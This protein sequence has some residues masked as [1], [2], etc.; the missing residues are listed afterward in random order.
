MGFIEY[1]WDISLQ[2][3]NVKTRIFM[4]PK[5]Q[6][7]TLTRNEA[8]FNITLPV[9]SMSE[10]GTICF[11]GCELPADSF[12]KAK[13]GRLF[14][15][16]VF[17][18]TAHTLMPICDEKRAYSIS[19]RTNVETFSESLVN[20]VYVNAYISAQHSD[21]LADLAFAKCTCLCKDETC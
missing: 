12:G 14:R 16:S 21:K 13:I 17:H 7:P 8:R 19:K 4:N 15:A 20:D 11:L 18:L 6:Q 10:E 5:L 3:D 9:P 2:K 1:A